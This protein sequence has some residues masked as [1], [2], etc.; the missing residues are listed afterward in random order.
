MCVYV[1][2]R[3]LGG[4]GNGICLGDGRKENCEGNAVKWLPWRCDYLRD[5]F[6]N[7]AV[8]S[9]TTTSAPTT[10]STTTTTATVPC[11]FEYKMKTWY[12]GRGGDL[13]EESEVATAA[14]EGNIASHGAG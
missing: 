5:S 9:S 2:V 12:R 14:S 13:H 11:L 3:V 6:A 7:V 8:I 4:V 1:S 10:I